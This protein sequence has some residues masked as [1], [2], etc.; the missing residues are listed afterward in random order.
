MKRNLF[1]LVLVTALVG[2]CGGGGG[3]GASA[4]TGVAPEVS[5]KPPINYRPALIADLI[6]SYSG[7]RRDDGTGI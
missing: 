7:I 4:P 6:G 1:P 3:G 2:G 5:R